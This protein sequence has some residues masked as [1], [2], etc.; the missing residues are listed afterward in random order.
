LNGL[1]Q[2]MTPEPPSG[3]NRRR[4]LKLTALTGST[5]ATGQ[6]LGLFS[7]RSALAQM[8]PAGSVRFAIIGDFGET[9]RTRS[10]RSTGSAR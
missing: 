2:V 10:S 6:L 4:F 3:M 5:L 9:L 7:P 8:P 1:P